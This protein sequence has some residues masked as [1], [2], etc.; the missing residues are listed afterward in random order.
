M[1]TAL[2][3]KKNTNDLRWI[4]FFG[5]LIASCTPMLLRL[6]ISMGNEIDTFD[7]KDLIFAG[8]SINLANLNLIGNKSFDYKVVVIFCSVVFLIAFAALIGTIL[9]FE[10]NLVIRPNP[11]RFYFCALATFATIFI[12]GVSNHYSNKSE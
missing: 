11:G 6:L 5:T 2:E 1:P 10:K 9:P 3:S 4:W 8:M 12:S 7:I